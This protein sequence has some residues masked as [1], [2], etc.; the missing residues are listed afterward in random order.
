MTRLSAL[1][2]QQKTVVLGS[3]FGWALDVYDL[4]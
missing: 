4:V 1:S 3:W 2:K